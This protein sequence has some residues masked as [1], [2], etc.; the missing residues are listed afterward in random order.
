MRINSISTTTGY[1]KGRATERLLNQGRECAKER[2]NLKQN[3]NDN[4]N[5]TI[6]SNSD[7]RVSFKGATPLLHKAANFASDNPLVAEALFAILI[8]C[9]LRPLTIMATAKTE[10]DKEKCSYQAA[11]SV[12]TG[13]IG[14][15]TS[16][17][18]G[19]PIAAAAKAAQK[20]GAFNMPEE[21]KKQSMEVV[22]QGA[23]NL[24]K[25]AEKFTSEGKHS[26]LV[27]QIKGLTAPMAKKG[28]INLGIFKKAGKSAEKIFKEKIDD[29]APEISESVK[30]AIN[31]QKTIDNFAR[32]GKNV[33]DK[34]FQPIFM[35]IRATITVALVPTILAALGLKKSSGKPKE[36][37]ITPYD[38]LSYN[39][40]KT[41]DDKKIFQAFSG[42]ANYE[43][44]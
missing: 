2:H 26:E 40:F 41:S 28:S 44:K 32:T 13:I 9:G 22:K 39:V 16:V 11:K 20:R 6:K 18:I 19:I 33:I 10:E 34:L 3:N 5:T 42:V 1:L 14:L 21:M 7:G 38:Y 35:P 37:Q 25:L 24:T 8:T 43:N 29:V 31:E 15:A 27:E 12:S 4:I 30:N 23:E 17:L 36:P